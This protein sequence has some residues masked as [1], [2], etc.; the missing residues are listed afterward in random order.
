M[1]GLWVVYGLPVFQT[2]NSTGNVALPCCITI[3][4]YPVS[5]PVKPII[6]MMYFVLLHFML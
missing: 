5:V 6:E 4:K 1:G 3:W 2:I